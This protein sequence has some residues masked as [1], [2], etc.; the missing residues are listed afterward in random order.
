MFSVHIHTHTRAA[1]TRASQ[2]NVVVKKKT[3]ILYR[4]SVWLMCMYKWKRFGVRRNRKKKIINKESERD[5]LLLPTGR[6]RLAAITWKL[7]LPLILLSRSHPITAAHTIYV[8][9]PT[10]ACSVSADAKCF[11][12]KNKR[13]HTHPPVILCCTACVYTEPMVIICVHNDFARCNVNARDRV[14]II[15]Y[16]L[17]LIIYLE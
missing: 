13:I 2:V 9:P 5:P 11:W 14:V 16:C 12:R 8:Y 17:R 4:I 15:N 3:Y 10:L 7:I 6:Y 1:Y